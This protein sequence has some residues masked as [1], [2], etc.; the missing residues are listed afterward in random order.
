MRDLA[1]I[2]GDVV[3]TTIQVEMVGE[4]EY[5]EWV[6]GEG[7]GELARPWG[8]GTYPFLGSGEG[9]KVDDGF[10]KRV[11]GRRSVGGREWIRETLERDREYKW[12]QWGS[13][14]GRE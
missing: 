5:V 9:G 14:L 13:S 3:G 1:G 10:V 4:K 2:V 7:R 12:H 11:L 8:L 6:E